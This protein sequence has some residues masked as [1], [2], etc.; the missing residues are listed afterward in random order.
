MLKIEFI[1]L[2]FNS[3]DINY[4]FKYIYYMYCNL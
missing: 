4:I 1:S 2:D 3:I